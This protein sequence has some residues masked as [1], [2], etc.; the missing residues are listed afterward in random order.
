MSPPG[1]NG[2]SGYVDTDMFDLGGFFRLVSRSVRYRKALVLWTT[3]V[4]LVSVTAYVIAWPP[5]YR[6]EAKLA[7]ERDLDP[8]RDQFY[9]NWQVFRKDDPRDEIQ[10]FTS[11]PV[12]R[13]V[14]AKNNLRYEDVYHPFLAHAG[15]LWETSW[16]GRAYT[17][18]KD[19]LM[20]EDNPVNP[21]YKEVGRMIDG[22]KAG[23]RIE[24]VA[25][26]HVATLEVKGPTRH[27]SE[28]TNSLID[29]YLAFRSKR[30]EAEAEKALTVLREESE[31]ARAALGA[32]RDK[33]VAFARE[34]GL[35]MEFQKESLEIKELTGLE[36]GISNETAKIASLEASLQVIDQQQKSE[37]PE[38]VLSSTRELNS[39]RENAR[40]RRLELQ[41]SLISLRDHYREDS[42][43]V[44]ET[45][46][47]LAKVDALIA[48]EPEQ[49]DR[50]VTQGVN[51][52]H[53]H[54]TSNHDQLQSELEGTRASVAS[55]NKKASDMRNR[56]TKLPVI[57]STAQDLNRE[58]DVAAEKY[59]RLLFRKMEAEVSKTALAVAPS[60]VSVVE[61]ATPPSSKY[62]PRFKYLYP[63]ALMAGLL[64]GTV[65][66]VIRSLTAGRLLQDH[67][68]R[69]RIAFPVYATIG[70]GGRARDIAVLPQQS[71]RAHLSA[72]A[73]QEHSDAD[74]SQRASA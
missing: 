18:V 12:L 25:D 16:P 62:W 52:I 61:Y 31:R 59:Q 73:S 38:K 6:V 43:E 69:G 10:L 71:K 1:N 32:I 55:M 60:T 22:L 72:N 68:E 45:L 56:L 40:M 19:S 65:A 5:I 28:V 74:R 20:P 63:G 13:E 51:S 46:A 36:T 67:I 17:A 7:V 21:E 2:W 53:D 23:I 48:K 42:P 3:L 4:T 35:M 39:V 27:V 33:R 30:H 54:L 58:Y 64:L 9:S 50:S 24:P 66:A 14:I 57:M 49:V 47:D 11:G 70:R 34:N 37:K 41:A 44:Q 29:T 26:T 15:Y 8:A